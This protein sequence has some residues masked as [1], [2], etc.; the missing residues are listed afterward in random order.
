MSAPKIAEAMHL[1]R[2]FD[3]TRYDSLERRRAHLLCQ[4]LDHRVPG[5]AD[6]NRQH[7]RV[8]LQIVKILADAQY[9]TLAMQVAREGSGDGRLSQRAEKDF[10]RGVAHLL[11]WSLAFAGCG[12]G[13]IIKTAV[14]CQLSAVS[15]TETPGW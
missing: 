6:G 5:F 12:H 1:G 4:R 3:R 10:A 15:Q 9:S 13:R 2:G 7:A 8:R 11:E 14:S